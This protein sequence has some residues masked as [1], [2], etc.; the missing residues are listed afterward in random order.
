[1]LSKEEIEK[2][3]TFKISVPLISNEEIRNIDNNFEN[4]IEEFTKSYVKEKEL[5]I[6]QYIMQKQQ[7]KIDQLESEKQ[8]LIEKLEEDK[9]EINKKIKKNNKIINMEWLDSHLSMDDYFARKNKTERE[10]E[11]LEMKIEYL[12]SFSKIVKRRK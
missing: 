1:M 10:N 5:V 12:K 3:N 2:D 7:N 4:I 8:K 6:A 9:K 11:I